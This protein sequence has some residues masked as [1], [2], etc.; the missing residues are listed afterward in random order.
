[1]GVVSD[2]PLYYP[3]DKL[4]NI[5]KDIK[6]H[7]GFRSRVY[8]DTLGIPTI[9]YGFAIKDLELDE[10]I[11]ELI[12]MRKI[13]QL[14]KRIISTFEWFEGSSDEVKYVVTN[15]CYQ[16]GVRGFSKFRKTIRLLKTKKYIEASKEMLL[17]KWAEQTPNR[18]NE[19]SKII[20]LIK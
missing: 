9:G 2:C 12:L 16:L 14:L 13:E 3:K 7:E 15:M 18:A 20:S 6:R 1:M 17:S 11:A 4:M 10:D 8:N 19:L 5:L